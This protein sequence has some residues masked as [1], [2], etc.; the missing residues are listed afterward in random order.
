MGSQDM[1]AHSFSTLG[2]AAGYY[3][4]ACLLLFAVLSAVSC[5]HSVY[6]LLRINRLRHASAHTQGHIIRLG[7]FTKRHTCL[8]HDSSGAAHELQTVFH[9]TCALGDSVEIV[10]NPKKPQEALAPA[11]DIGMLQLK[12]TAETIVF[13]LGSVLLLFAFFNTLPQP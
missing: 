10:Y 6:A 8:Y 3:P 7:G 9:R 11:V 2:S 4:A 1:F 13:S 12:Y 5:I